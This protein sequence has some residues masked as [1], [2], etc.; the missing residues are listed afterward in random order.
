MQSLDNLGVAGSAAKLH[1][2]SKLPQMLPVGEG[3]ILVD[4]VSL[5]VL[6]LVT[7]LLEAA[8]ITDLGMGSVRPLSGDEVGQGYLAIDPFPFQVAQKPGFRVA[9]GTCYLTMAG[10][11]PG[12]YIR[13]HLVAETTERRG[14]RKLEKGGRSRL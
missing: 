1:P 4:H 12:F 3:N 13:T 11:L 6:D 14:L 9:L 8:R 10:G 2:S 7:S 5:E